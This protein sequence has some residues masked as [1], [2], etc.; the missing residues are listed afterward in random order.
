MT[1]LH[2]DNLPPAS[3]STLPDADPPKHAGVEKD[4]TQIPISKRREQAEAPAETLSLMGRLASL[5]DKWLLGGNG[6]SWLISAVVHAGFILALSMFVFTRP[7]EGRLGWLDVETS[8]KDILSS[9]LDLNELD[10]MGGE[11][12]MPS[13]ASSSSLTSMASDVSTSLSIDLPSDHP[14]KLQ[15]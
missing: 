12:S 8:T 10:A 9:D 5:L 11:F 14:F 3:G 2:T 7:N 1:P 6:P 4:Q 15:P 13:E